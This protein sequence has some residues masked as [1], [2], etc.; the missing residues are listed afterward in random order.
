[1]ALS[2]FN[3]FLVEKSLAEIIDINKW[4]IRMLNMID[5]KKVTKDFNKNEKDLKEFYRLRNKW[6]ISSF[7]Y[8]ML[9]NNI[10]II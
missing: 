10:I 7:K 4:S 1:M 5:M 3:K 2:R 9:K 8:S 6:E